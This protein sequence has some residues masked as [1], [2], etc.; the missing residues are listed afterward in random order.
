MDS[1]S[2]SPKR[3]EISSLG[4]FG[5]IDRLTSGIELKN[6]SSLYGAG[7]DAAVISAG[8][9]MVKVVTTDLLLEGIHFDLM[10]HPLQHLG[11]KAIAVNVSDIY[12]MNATPEQVIVGLGLSNR[13]SVEAVEEIYAGMLAACEKYGVDLVG[14]DTNSSNKGL[15]I[16]ITAIGTARQEDVVYRHGAKPGD[17]LMVSGDLGA[18]Y[19]GLQIL[20]REKKLFLENPEIQPDLE[21]ESYLVGR[22]LLPKARKD[23]HELLEEL[24]IRPTSMIDISDGLSSD[25]LH[26][27]HRSGVGCRVREEAIPIAEEARNRALQ[28]NLVPSTCALNGGEDYELLF[29]V[30]PEDAQKLSQ[31]PDVTVIGDITLAK[32]GRVLVT[33]S[34]QV[35]EL[36]AQGWQHI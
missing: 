17:V 28:F 29:T 18:A 5:L 26:I 27:C 24:S 1:G 23:I 10:Y 13:F 9:G 25:L 35:H 30:R 14:G 32:D 19:L 16:S 22:Q 21:N 4:E 15:V 31:F 11:F 8:D 6:Q 12:A 20:E 3:T 7:D 36:I 33:R 34:G 2:A